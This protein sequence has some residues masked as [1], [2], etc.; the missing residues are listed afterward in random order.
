MQPISTI[1]VDDEP[2][3]RQ[4]VLD[5]LAREPDIDLLAECADG[6]AAIAALTAW[7]PDLAFLDVQMPE[8]DGFQVLAA[9]DPAHLPTVVFVTAYDRYAL[10]AF[11]VHALDYLLKPYDDERFQQ[12]LQRARTAILQKKTCELHERLLALIQTYPAPAPPGLSGVSASAPPA[13]IDRFVVKTGG[14]SWLIKADEIDYI[15][16]EGVYVRLHAAG[17]S[18]LV[19]ERIAELEACLNPRMFCRIHRSTI[20]NLERIKKLVPYFHGDYLAVLHDGT[21]LKLSRSRRDHLQA[22]LGLSF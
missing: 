15:Q 4:R 1:V 7:K 9:I 19:R 14:E 16:G 10:R 13:G 20:V 18:Y 11:D 12:A 5:L 22:R 6:Y 21:R 2:L 8:I 17:K 3:A